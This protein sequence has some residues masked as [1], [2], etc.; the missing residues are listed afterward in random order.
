[1][2]GGGRGAQKA[3]HDASGR[4]EAVNINIF[5]FFTNYLSRF[6]PGSSLVVR[7]CQY[8]ADGW[9]RKMVTK[10]ERAWS[11]ATAG[12]FDA[13]CAVDLVHM[14]VGIQKIVT[15]V[16]NTISVGPLIPRNIPEFLDERR[17]PS[18]AG[19]SRANHLIVALLDELPSSR[20][21]AKKERAPADCVLL[22]KYIMEAGGDIQENFPCVPTSEESDNGV[23]DE[24]I[25]VDR[26]EPTSQGAHGA[27]PSLFCPFVLAAETVAYRFF[28]FT[29]HHAMIQIPLASLYHHNPSGAVFGE[30]FGHVLT[31][32]PAG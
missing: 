10:V 29:A 20:N 16:E 25:G 4:S 19:S 28:R 18:S 9:S 15:S 14:F 3:I 22:L 17:G 2:K 5:N 32:N 12:E 6:Q 31:P 1:M 30:Q 27:F 24:R 23:G 26:F 21:K 7:Q 13:D 8:G 11:W